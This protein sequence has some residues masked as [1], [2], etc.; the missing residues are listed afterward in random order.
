LICVKESATIYHRN[1]R[2]LL[3]TTLNDIADKKYM[4]VSTQTCKNAAFLEAVPH[5][6]LCVISISLPAFN[7]IGLQV[8]KHIFKG[9]ILQGEIPVF[10]AC[11][12]LCQGDAMTRPHDKTIKSNKALQ[13]GTMFIAGILRDQSYRNY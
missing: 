5:D 3:F 12:Q 4:P 8:P 7:A 6:L 13:L 9:V 1:R 11:S 10:V 2:D